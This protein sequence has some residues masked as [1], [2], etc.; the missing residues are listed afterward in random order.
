MAKAN[1]GGKGRKM[2]TAARITAFL[3][4][5]ALCAM[6]S[7]AADQEAVKPDPS[8]WSHW[9][10]IKADSKPAVEGYLLAELDGKVYDHSRVD[11]TDLRVV[12]NQGSFV[13]YLIVNPLLEKRLKYQIRPLQAVVEDLGVE[14]DGNVSTLILDLGYRHI[15]SSKLE[16]KPA[17]PNFHRQLE[18]KAGNDKQKWE[19]ISQHEISSIR[20]GKVSKE[21]LQ[22]QLD[23]L[24]YR[25][26]RISVYNKD[27]K[28]IR[29]DEVKVFG[30]AHQLVFKYE[31]EKNYRL[32]YG[33]ESADSPHYDIQQMLPFIKIN[34]LPKAALSGEMETAKAEPPKA[35]VSSRKQ[36]ILLW[37]ILSVT[38]LILGGLIYRLAKISSV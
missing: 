26:L 31:P 27:D 35:D 28:P 23:D 30:Y 25:Y 3:F 8:Q 17:E 16:F 36:N 20:M 33:R 7:G 12:D 21:Q 9:R 15:P 2:I 11:L 1:R 5:F 34:M 19:F 10:E 32:I 6:P 29:F 13:P 38:A 22:I 37:A 24:R 14:K 18:I 4:V